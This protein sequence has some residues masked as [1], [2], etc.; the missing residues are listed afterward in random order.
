MSFFDIIRQNMTEIAKKVEKISNL[1]MYILFEKH[2]MRISVLLREKWKEGSKCFQKWE[3]QMRE[4]LDK[5]LHMKLHP[6]FFRR[7]LSVILTIAI[8]MTSLGYGPWVRQTEAATSYTTLYLVDDTPE[9]WLGNDN[10]VIELVDNT[11]G[12]DHYIMTKENSTTWSVRVPSTT[13]NVT[14][15]RLSPDKSTQWNSWSAGGR[16]T[17]STYHAITHEHGYWDGTAVL[18]EG[19]KA[20]DVIYL[21]F[22]EFQ[23]W[24]NASAVFYVNFTDASKADNNGQDIS[25]GSADSDLFSPSLLTDEIEDDVFTYTVTEEEEGATELRFWR[26]TAV[27]FGTAR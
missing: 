26:E 5:T 9:Q 16:D 6:K 18:E 25:I 3:V 19:F 14:F 27:P 22:Y 20:G 24:K 10:A 15:N 2:I 8:V 11:S 12:H 13:Y 23:N 4:Q 17:H 1:L 7:W 21:D